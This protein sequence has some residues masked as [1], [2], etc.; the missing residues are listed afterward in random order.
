M[1]FSLANAEAYDCEVLPN[2][3]TFAMECLHS[4]TKAVWEISEFRDD[5]ASLLEHFRYLNQTQ[6]PLIGFNSVG[7]DYAI[8]HMLW[9]NPD[10]TYQ[11]LR[12]KSLAIIKGNDRWGH[13]VWASDRFCPQIDLLKM[14]H[15]DNRAKATGL[16]ALQINMRAENVVESSLPFDR[17][18]TQQEIDGDLIPYNQHD[19][20]ETKRFALYSMNAIEFRIGL[21]QQFGLDVL[22]WNDTKIGEQMVIQRLGDEVCYDR[23]TGKRRTRQTPRNEIRIADI[24]FPYIRFQHPEFNRVLDYLKQQVL[25]PDDMKMDDDG[26]P[27]LQTKGVFTGLSATV[28]GF[29]FDYGVGGIHGSVHRKRVIATDEW[30][31]RDIDVAA[32]Y[33]NIAIQN[34]LYPEH[35]GQRFVDVY[36][37]LPLERK[38]WQEQK[39]KKCAEANALKLASNGTYGKSNSIFSPLFDPR[40]TMSITINGQ[41]MLSM[42]AEK[43]M[44]IPTLTLLAINTDGMTYQIHSSQLEAAKSVEREWEQLTRLTLEDAAYSRMF[45]RDVNSF[46][47]QYTDGILKLKGA[48]WSPD[49]LNYHQSIADA[50]PVS[51][52]KRFD[53]LV[54]TRAAVAHM[55]DGVDIETYIRMCTN[56]YDFCCAVKINRSDKLLWGGVEQQRNTRFFV[57]TEG[58]GLVKISPPAGKPGAF[59]KAN[60][61]TDAEYARVMAETGGAWDERVC[62]KNRSVYEQRNSA[63]MAGY[64]VQVVNDISKFDFSKIN[65]DWY[66]QEALKLVI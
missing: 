38:R 44:Q 5:R 61:V 12:Q 31:I 43:L 42:L 15:F 9:Q 33:P 26:V 23:S 52:H 45:I 37:Q 58:E 27:L 57:A 22:N 62:T 36:S 60:G 25:R 13:Q 66:L 40:F 6:T 51:W 16:K 34:G 41:L 7:Y 56:P 49:T 21:V 14:H 19:V 18:L 59:K 17:P 50:Q 24:I 4:D 48:Y 53:A 1:T 11:Q 32:L 63:V 35:L 8:I 3:F 29:Q 65:Y 46:I 55:V 64:K 47:G 30:L 10:I 28:N 20:S 54:S 39:G 2:C